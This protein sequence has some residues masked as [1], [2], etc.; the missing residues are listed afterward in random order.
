MHHGTV[1]ED[2]LFGRP[3]ANQKVK[4]KMSDMG[5]FLDVSFRPLRGHPGCQSQMVSRKRSCFPQLSLGV[6]ILRSVNDVVPSLGEAPTQ[7]CII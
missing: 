1:L 7:C 5:T 4:T 6:I 2:G 3:T